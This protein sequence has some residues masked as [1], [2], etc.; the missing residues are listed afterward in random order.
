MT[1]SSFAAPI[2]VTRPFLPPLPEFYTGLQEIWNN[3]W[4]TNR[5]PVLQRFQEK[6]G[7]YF[8]TENLCLFNNGTLALQ[9]GMQGLEL[10]GDVIT[11]PFTFVATAHALHWNNLRPVFVD[12]EPEYYTLDPAQVEKAITPQ[13]TAILAVH[14]YGYPCRLKELAEIARRHGLFLLYD[15]AHAF[16]VNV[17]GKSIGH[18]GDLTMFSFH[19]TKLFH[20]IEGGMLM[21]SDV[22]RK[23]TFDYLK[24]FG[25]AGETEVVMPGTNAKMNEFQAHMGSLVLQYIPGIIARRGQ[26]DALYREGLKGIPGIHVPAV[27]PGNVDYNYAYFPIEIDVAA[28]GMS[29]DELYLALK[30]FNVITRRYFYPLVTDFAC[31]RSLVHDD[32]LTVARGVAQRVLTLPIYDSLALEDVERIGGMLRYLH[33]SAQV[34]VTAVPALTPTAAKMT[35]KILILGGSHFQIPVIK[36]ARSAGYHVVTCDFL[37]EN[38][39]HKLANE[40]YNVSTTD[41]EGVLALSIRLKID[42]ILAYA[43]D[44][45]APTAAYVSEKLGL[46]GNRFE[47]VQIM[48]N[49]DRYRAFLYRHGFAAPKA[50]A[51]F[52]LNSP[53]SAVAGLKFPVMVKPV[54]SSGSKGVSKI[55]T[56][57]TLFA[58][59]EYAGK[60]SRAKRV[61]VE[62]FLPRKG[63]QIGGEAFVADGKLVFMCLGDQRV[64]AACNPHVPTGMTFPSQLA[65]GLAKKIAAELQRLLTALQFSNGGLN[66]EIMLDGENRIFFMEIGPRT[67]GNFLPELVGYASGFNLAAASVESALNQSIAG[68]RPDGMISTPQAGFAYYAIHSSCSG[69]LTSLQIDPAWQSCILEIHQFV[70][71]GGVVHAYHGSNCTIGILLLRFSSAAEMHEKMLAVNRAVTATVEERPVPSAA[72]LSVPP[73][74]T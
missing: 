6:L 58:A 32:P 36:Y 57:D 67:G 7:T 11:T 73:L 35:K 61:I 13:T 55:N 17:D 71:I 60:F 8:S 52:T 3:Q 56:A 34:A 16:G 59:V 62:E 65:P 49:K 26:I 41:L 50:I 28:F 30:K 33:R 37:P 20:S 29:R 27:L 38:P 12:I 4:L 21:F 19:A 64:D 43:S 5:G 54:D 45:A 40:Y 44:P 46:Q 53:L 48:A 42:G 9:I 47:A 74:L 15:A 18:Q 2:Y 1:L 23:R 14:V 22:A 39:G 51:D 10:S 66:L 24:N 72:L 31:Y 63:P 25:F 68:P 69:V 70:P